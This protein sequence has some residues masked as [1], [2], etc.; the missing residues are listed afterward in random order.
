MELKFRVGSILSLVA[1]LQQR[2]LQA[3]TTSSFG[4][5]TSKYWKKCV[6][7]LLQRHLTYF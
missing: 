7:L 4:F 3:M 1:H 5:V 6:F 2:Q